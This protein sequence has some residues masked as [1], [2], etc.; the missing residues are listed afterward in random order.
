[1]RLSVSS[2]RRPPLKPWPQATS[3]NPGVNRMSII[4][5]LIRPLTKIV[6]GDTS[7]PQEF[8]IGMR[9]PQG[10]IAVFLH[11]FEAPLDVTERHTMACCAPFIMGVSLDSNGNSASRTNSDISLRYCERGGNKS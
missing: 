7:I 4:G 3:S 11:G 2:R 1:M 10:E 9:Q 6:Y 5:Q 8:T